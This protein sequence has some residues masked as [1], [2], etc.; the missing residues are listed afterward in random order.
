[1]PVSALSLPGP[2]LTRNDGQPANDSGPYCAVAPGRPL[3]S[4]GL[5]ESTLALITLPATSPST[6]VTRS[7]GAGHDRPGAPH[8]GGPMTG[9]AWSHDRGKLGSD[10]PHARG[11]RHLIRDVSARDQVE[12]GWIS[13]GADRDRGRNPLPEW[14]VTRRLRRYVEPCSRQWLSAARGTQT[15]LVRASW[16]QRGH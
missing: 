3:R 11:E 9:N 15:G 13:T 10:R 7:L 1:M 6:P 14:T 8:V 12:A 4:N 5:S 16:R 2:T